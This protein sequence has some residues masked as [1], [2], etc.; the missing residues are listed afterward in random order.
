MSKN[1]SLELVKCGI[2]NNLTNII[3]WNLA[4]RY[5]KYATLFDKYIGRVSAV[6]AYATCKR[7]MF[8]FGVQVPYSTKRTH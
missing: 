4:R 6:N 5:R 1:N 8:K 7:T 2:D 3:D